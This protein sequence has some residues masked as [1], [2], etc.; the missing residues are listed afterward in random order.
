MPFQSEIRPSQVNDLLEKVQNKNY[1]KYL[2]KISIEKARAFQGRSI[3]FDFPVTAIVGINGGGKT[4]V[5]GA[6][7]CAYKTVK[8]SLFLQKV[9]D[10]IQVC[11]TGNLSMS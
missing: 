11:R 9:V 2:L 8:P 4:T 10:L 6:A 3:N 7:A 5:L 1:G